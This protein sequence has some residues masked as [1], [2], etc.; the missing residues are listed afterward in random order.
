[1]RDWCRR[2]GGIVV[3]GVLLIV[4]LLCAASILATEH[5]R[6][7]SCA[8]EKVSAGMSEEEAAVMCR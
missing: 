6:V 2:Y 5:N 4:G 1:M 8:K 7:N 3:V